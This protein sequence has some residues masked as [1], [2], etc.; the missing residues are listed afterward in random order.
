ME[1]LPSDILPLLF[2]FLPSFTELGR[3][4]SVSKEFN[5]IIN[6]D[7]SLW[8]SLCFDWWGDQLEFKPFDAVHTQL[9]NIGNNHVLSWAQSQVLSFNP[10]FSWKWFG[11]C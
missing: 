5:Q 4:A 7:E 1:I 11:K 2:S 6:R 9:N 10:I 8:M 3:M